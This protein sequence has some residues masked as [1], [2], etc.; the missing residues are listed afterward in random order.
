[1]SLI[2]E[3]FLLCDSDECNETYGVEDGDDRGVILRRDGN[4]EGWNFKN[5]KDY[6][7]VCTLNYRN[8]KDNK[9]LT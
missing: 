8:S 4:I 2:I 9:R 6:C 5:K 3:K 7:V 1:M